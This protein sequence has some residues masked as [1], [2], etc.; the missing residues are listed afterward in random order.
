MTPTGRIARLPLAALAVSTVLLAGCGGDD[1]G[2]AP[3]V[4]GIGLPDAKR[5]LKDAG[6]ETTTKSDGLLGV[7]VEENWTVCKQKAPK[8]QLV[9]IEVSKVC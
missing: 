2:S 6:F 9:P 1:L 7:L 5:I 3:D 4:R 8:G